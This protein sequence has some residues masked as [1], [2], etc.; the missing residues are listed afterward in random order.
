MKL[1]CPRASD[2]SLRNE[3]AAFAPGLSSGRRGLAITSFTASKIRSGSWRRSAA[4]AN[5]SRPSEKCHPVHGHPAR[6]FPPSVEDHR[7]LRG[8]P[9]R[10]AAP[11]LQHNTDA[12]SAAILVRPRPEW[13]RSVKISPGT[14]P[15]DALPKREHAAP[16]KYARLRIQQLTQTIRQSPASQHHRRFVVHQAAFNT[17]RSFSRLLVPPATMV[18]VRRGRKR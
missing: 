11:G 12:T 18:C 10:Q 15:P 13:S 17:A 9:T 6:G 8:L 16:A 4:A 1:A 3:P 5:K 2:V 7:L 14:T